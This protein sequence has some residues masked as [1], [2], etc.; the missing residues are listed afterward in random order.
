M[1]DHS[2]DP[3]TRTAADRPAPNP[4]HPVPYGP[5]PYGSQ[6]AQRERDL[7]RN[8]I[9]R[10]E[11][12]ELS[13]YRWYHS[14]VPAH[15]QPGKS[16][17]LAQTVKDRFYTVTGDTLNYETDMGWVSVPLPKVLDS[18]KGGL[19]GF[20]IGATQT[21]LGQ[22]TRRIK[23]WLDAMR[24]AGYLA[25]G[26]KAYKTAE[27]ALRKQG[28]PSVLFENDLAI[29]MNL[30]AD[31]PTGRKLIDDW[32]NA[33]VDEVTENLN[34][35]LIGTF[36][37]EGRGVL[38]PRHPNYD[39]AMMLLAAFVNNSPGG[40][41]NW[42]HA[43]RAI[44]ALANPT[45]EDLTKEMLKVQSF[46]TSSG[47]NTLRKLGHKV[48]P[49]SP[50][51][52][53]SPVPPPVVSAPQQSPPMPSAGKQAAPI[54]TPMPT[55]GP[56]GGPTGSPFPVPADERAAPMLPD[57]PGGPAWG[58][59]QAPAGGQPK[60]VFQNPPPP[61]SGGREAFL[62]PGRGGTLSPVAYAPEPGFGYGGPGAGFRPMAAS[63]SPPGMGLGWPFASPRV[64]TQ[65]VPPPRLPGLLD[66]IAPG[67][68]NPPPPPGGLLDALL[69]T[70][71]PEEQNPAPPMGLLGQYL[72]RNG[73]GMG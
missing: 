58:A 53:K 47:P 12:G 38:D 65:A 68:D 45:M 61:P 60:P 57:A 20:S 62:A 46:A 33:N 73:N 9:R 23:Q 64:P 8:G 56:T 34:R 54:P 63:H 41:Y 50:P 14:R 55:S 70:H 16:W 39:D 6:M 72:F 69:S 15:D 24:E 18:Q 1:S 27:K 19:A 67:W 26:E 17:K 44:G 7:F 43:L 10:V 30:F 32:D 52:T 21:D 29:D 2:N 4:P 3:R 25:P 35:Y 51:A 13:P 11:I 28:D 49:A 48:P 37:Q 31:T 59:P 42:T 22:K 36:P 71:A 40:K 66:R 5:V